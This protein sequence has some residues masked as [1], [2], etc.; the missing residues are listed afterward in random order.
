MEKF[1]QIVGVM[2]LAV[3]TFFA[4]LAILCKIWNLTTASLNAPHLTMTQMF[5]ISIFIASVT[6]EHKK[7]GEI[8]LADTVA[9]SLTSMVGL[10]IS[11]GLAQLVFG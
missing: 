7:T 11:W 5:G 10:L 3:V 9:S 4:R 1:L 8:E 6:Y 2:A